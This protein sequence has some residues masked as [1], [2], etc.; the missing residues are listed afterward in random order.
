M[1]SLEDHVTTTRGYA[2]ADEAGVIVATWPNNDMEKIPFPYS[3]EVWT[4]L[5]YTATSGMMYVGMH[6]EAVQIVTDARNRFE[7]TRRNPFNEMEY[8]NHDVRAMASW[9]T[10]LAESGFHFS[11][12]DHSM[13]FAGKEGTWFWSNGYAW[14]NC[15]IGLDNENTHIVLEVLQGEVNLNQFTIKGVGVKK[16]KKLQTIGVDKV[17]EFQL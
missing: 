6:D 4:G 11:A 1:G 14:G 7:G 5:E 15:T 12:V 3:S 16:F 13:E 9:A 10:V 8:G 2:L 17:L